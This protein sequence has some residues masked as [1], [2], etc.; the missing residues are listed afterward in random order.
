MRNLRPDHLASMARVEIERAFPSVTVCDGLHTG[1]AW[2]PHQLGARQYDGSGL[3][4]AP[5]GSGKTEAAL[6]WA[7]RQAELGCQGRLCFVL[8]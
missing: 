5:T 7:S 1:F 8:P 6:L 2:K 4:I 3:L